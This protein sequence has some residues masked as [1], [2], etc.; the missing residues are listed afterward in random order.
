MSGVGLQSVTKFKHCSMNGI[1]VHVLALHRLI[2]ATF[3]R[4][5]HTGENLKIQLDTQLSTNHTNFL[6][7]PADSFCTA[8]KRQ[9]SLKMHISATKNSFL[10]EGSMPP[11]PLEAQA[12]PSCQGFTIQ[13]LFEPLGP[14][15]SRPA[16]RLAEEKD[17]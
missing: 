6:I 8:K 2:Q 1:P 10:G 11:D 12:P 7:G 4:S 13:N 5:L 9:N 14:C 3:L 17:K 16:T 15:K